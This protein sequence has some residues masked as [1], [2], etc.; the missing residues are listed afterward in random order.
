[1]SFTD[2]PEGGYTREF[3]RSGYGKVGRRER[4][5]IRVLRRRGKVLD[6]LSR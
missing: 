3:E 5:L 4:S 6:A 1:V 2:S